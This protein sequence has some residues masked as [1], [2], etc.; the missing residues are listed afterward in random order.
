MVSAPAG[1]PLRSVIQAV[2]GALKGSGGVREGGGVMTLPSVGGLAR[3]SASVTRPAAPPAPSWLLCRSWPVYVTVS[4]TC[5]PSE[6]FKNG[7]CHLVLSHPRWNLR[8]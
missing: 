8:H 7:F 2:R 4:A 6:Q 3:W 5:L 1:E